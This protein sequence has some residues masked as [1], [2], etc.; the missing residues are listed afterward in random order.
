MKRLQVI[1]FSAL[2]LAT[3][4][5]YAG[6]RHHD[7]DRQWSRDGQHQSRGD[8]QK[9]FSRNYTRNGK[10]CRDKPKSVPELDA[11]GAGL[12]LGLVVAVA[13]ARRERLNARKL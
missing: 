10:Q 13:A 4:L 11:G 5:S 2:M 12:A 8:R 6:G 9:Q 1:L 7:G 3:S